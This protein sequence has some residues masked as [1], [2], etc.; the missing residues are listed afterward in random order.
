MLMDKEFGLI[1][2]VREVM[3]T[4]YWRSH[5]HPFVDKQE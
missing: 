4:Y 2:T 3:P 1:E 5:E